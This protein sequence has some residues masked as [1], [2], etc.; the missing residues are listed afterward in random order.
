[1]CTQSM[2]LS[3]FL[4]FAA[5]LTVQFRCQTGHCIL[6]DDYCNG[7][8]DCADGSD[9][10]IACN[11]T[12]VLHPVLGS[13]NGNNSEKMANTSGPTTLSF[14]SAALVVTSKTAE[15]SSVS[16]QSQSI[17]SLAIR[18]SPPVSNAMSATSSEFTSQQGSSPSTIVSTAV[19]STSNSQTSC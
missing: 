17:S 15:S 16:Y 9:E 2:R 14:T 1:M 19:P 6:L 12:T 18:T 7:H 13:T 3:V 4:C 10:P 8:F 5:C 11:R